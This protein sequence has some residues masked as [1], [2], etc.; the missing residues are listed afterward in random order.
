MAS[1][2]FGLASVTF[3]F[4]GF[5]G[6]WAGVWLWLLVGGLAL[7]VPRPHPSALVQ[8]KSTGESRTTAEQKLDPGSL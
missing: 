3:D 5:R 4:G 1:L 2:G 7:M 6:V 8:G